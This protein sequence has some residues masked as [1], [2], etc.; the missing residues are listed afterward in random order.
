MCVTVWVVLP[1]VVFHYGSVRAEEDGTTCPGVFWVFFLQIFHLQFS[2]PEDK[3]R[4]E[5]GG[6]TSRRRH[7]S[8]PNVGLK[9]LPSLSWV[10]QSSC[11]LWPR[12]TIHSINSGFLKI[13][14]LASRL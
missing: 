9:L 11:P 5:T 7:G 2:F 10:N 4:G 13:N 6:G 12:L 3:R 1:S 14:L 8:D